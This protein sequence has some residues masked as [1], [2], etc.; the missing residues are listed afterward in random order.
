MDNPEKVMM[1]NIEKKFG[2]PFGEWIK[3]VKKQKLEK[4]NEILKFLKERHGFTHGYANLVSMKAR[5]TDSASAESSEHL[6]SDQYKGKE[7]LLSIYEKIIKEISTF[8]NDIEIAP[9]KAAVSLRRKRQFAL[10]QPSTK[11]RVDLGLKLKDKEISGRLEGS[12]PFGTMC[13]HR[14]KIH[15]PNEVNLE[16]ISWLKEAYEKAG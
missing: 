4:H 8:G 9:K 16:I 15:D 5:G 12:G 10:I 3:I 1:Q 2:K 11:T 7:N 13:T 14:V 6:I